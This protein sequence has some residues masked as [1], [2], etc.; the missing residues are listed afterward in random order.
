MVDYNYT[1][2]NKKPSKKN[3]VVVDTD[4]LDAELDRAVKFS[5]DPENAMVEFPS[6]RIHLMRVHVNGYE[7]PVIESGRV[8][9]KFLIKICFF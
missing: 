8:E 3:H 5:Q 9:I 2:E 1:E 6:D 4:T 7:V